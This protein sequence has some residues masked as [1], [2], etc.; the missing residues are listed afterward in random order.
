MPSLSQLKVLALAPTY[1]VPGKKDVTG[2]FLPEA[3]AFVKLAKKG[4]RLVQ[5]DNSRSLPQRRAEVLKLLKGD[6]KGYDSVALFCHG[7]LDGV[8]AGFL[9]RHTTELAEAISAITLTE[10]VVV[11]LYCCSTGKDPQDDP[12]TAA[13]TG[14]DSFAD[15][16]RDA[17][18]AEG[19]VGCRVMAHTTVAHCT[20]N[21]MVV[22]MDGM[23]SS[24]GGVGG[25]PPVSPGSENWGR[26]R[27]A[28]RTTDLRL[29]MPYMT[30]ADIHAELEP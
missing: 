27:K 24:S 13:G 6:S 8:Q 14:D 25:Y 22:F 9:R 15:K 12:L 19:A 7:W 30:P 2:A 17:L 20:K 11:P 16:L 3:K 23:G 4:S 1:N 5:F 18:C 26:W 21:P 10:D 29:R 28:L